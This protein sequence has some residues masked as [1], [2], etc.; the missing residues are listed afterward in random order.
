MAGTNRTNETQVENGP[1]V[2]L[3]ETQLG[4]NIGMAARAMLNC[5]L[6][7]MRLVA[8]RDG[9]P[10]DRAVTASAGALDV[11]NS[12]E[13]FE[14]TAAAIADLNTVYAASAR[15]RHALKEIVTP[16][17]AAAEMRA[18]PADAKIGVLFG[19]EKSGLDN[20]DIAL[21]DRIIE[22]PLNP[23]FASLNISQAVLIVAWEWSQ[24]GREETGPELPM[25]H[26][27]PAEKDEL[28][29]MFAHLEDE[30]DARGFLK[31]A[32]KRTNMVRNIRNLFQ[33]MSMTDQE[34]RTMRGI[35]SSLTRHPR[36]DGK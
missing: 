24:T 1:I 10:N 3:V 26:T 19:P 11:V 7:R 5:G 18:A 15:R 33:R 25:G 17:L 31:P 20:D 21:A 28:L 12:A 34:V 6:A 36:R 23:A 2:I 30:L 27:F 32:E 16:G 13:V 8:P 29:R 35:I 22:A 4:E 14:T 9:W